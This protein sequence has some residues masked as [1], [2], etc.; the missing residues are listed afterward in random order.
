[1]DNTS[2]KISE[3]LTTKIKRKGKGRKKKINTPNIKGII[4]DLSGITF[5]FD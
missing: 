1:M 2:N 4:K 5:T 3:V